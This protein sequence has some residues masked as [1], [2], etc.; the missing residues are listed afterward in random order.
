MRLDRNQGNYSFPG[1]RYR[2]QPLLGLGTIQE[3]VCSD[4]QAAQE[5]K[6]R[7]DE[8]MQTSMIVAAG[9]SVAAGLIGSLF[10]KPAAGA[11]AGG[12]AGGLL[13]TVWSKMYRE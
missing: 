5:C 6:A 10:Q 3:Y 2:S 12:L 11:L 4:T 8:T 13:Y 1:R 9:V 7:R